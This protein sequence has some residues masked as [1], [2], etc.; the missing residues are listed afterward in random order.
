MAIRE[1][2]KDGTTR[3]SGGDMS[4]IPGPAGTRWG[5]TTVFLFGSSFPN[6]EV[7]FPDGGMPR[8]GDIVVSTNPLGPGAVAV[9]SGVVDLTH[10]DLSPAYFSIQG[11]EGPQGLQGP[12]GPNVSS[13]TGPSSST[14]GFSMGVSVAA[15]V[16]TT[17]LNAPFTPPVG[18]K[19]ALIHVSGGIKST[20]NCAAT[21][22]ILVD[23][24]LKKAIRFHNGSAANIPISGS[25]S[26]FFDLAAY[27]L[28]VAIPFLINLTTDAGS[29]APAVTMIHN[30]SIDYL[31]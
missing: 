20:A 4:G 8:I 1:K 12:A 19:V 27:S 3:I 21:E 16:T 31:K 6:S 10:A 26:F 14:A 15:G 22:N 9:V 13:T 23:G 18:S 11:P 17:L 29:S 2:L 28:P 7:F 5:A 30:Y 24:V 25:Q